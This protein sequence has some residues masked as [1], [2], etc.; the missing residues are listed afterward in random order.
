MVVVSL[1]LM[2]HH[3]ATASRVIVRAAT[4]TKATGGRV[5]RKEAA[6]KTPHS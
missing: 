1:W 5:L 6:A 4:V 3:L 2:C